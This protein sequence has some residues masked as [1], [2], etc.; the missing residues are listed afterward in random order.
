MSYAP[1]PAP[2]TL[3]PAQAGISFTFGSKPVH[4]IC[5]SGRITLCNA[6]GVPAPNRYTIQ[7]DDICCQCYRIAHEHDYIH[8]R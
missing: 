2:R 1:Q 7:L 5:G 8:R 6:L 3:Y 4:V